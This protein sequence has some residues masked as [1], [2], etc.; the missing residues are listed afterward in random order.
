[1]KDYVSRELAKLKK[2]F[3]HAVEDIYSSAI[4]DQLAEKGRLDIEIKSDEEYWQGVLAVAS[5]VG[6]FFFEDFD[7]AVDYLSACAREDASHLIIA[8]EKASSKA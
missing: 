3:A 7:R 6:E 2:N 5:G 8:S 1:M 4:L